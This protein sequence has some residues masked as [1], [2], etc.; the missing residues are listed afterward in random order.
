MPC[1]PTFHLSVHYMCVGCPGTQ[2]DVTIY[3]VE[4]RTK[5]LC[6]KKNYVGQKLVAYF[7]LLATMQ[8]KWLL[9]QFFHM[10]SNAQDF[11]LKKYLFNILGQ[12]RIIQL[13]L[14]DLDI[15]EHFVSIYS[16]WTTS[17]IGKLLDRLALLII[18]HSPFYYGLG[19]DHFK[20]FGG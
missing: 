4:T 9:K 11:T 7:S 5:L 19:G 1:L 14:V 17:N 13:V 20:D 2:W 15:F 10:I 6:R 8:N 12:R 16:R 3:V 18:D